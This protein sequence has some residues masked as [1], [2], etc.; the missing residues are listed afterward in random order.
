MWLLRVLG[1]RVART[2][3][4]M[5]EYRIKPSIIEYYRYEHHVAK[6]DFVINKRSTL[7]I[8]VNPGIRQSTGFVSN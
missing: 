7:L 2:R 8:I 4:D 5:L 6:S 3:T 1:R